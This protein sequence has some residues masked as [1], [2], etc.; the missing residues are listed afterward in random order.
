MRTLHHYTS[1]NGDPCVAHGH[2]DAG[3][4]TYTVSFVEQASPC[5]WVLVPDEVYECSD[6]LRA[7]SEFLWLRVDDVTGAITGFKIDHFQRAN[8]KYQF[9]KSLARIFSL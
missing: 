2:Y 8:H 9:T 4:D 6:E 5:H 1:V 3:S 7:A